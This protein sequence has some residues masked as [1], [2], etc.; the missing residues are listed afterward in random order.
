MG[1]RD[2]L[3]IVAR[4]EAITITWIRSYLRFGPD[5]PLW[6]FVA[7][8]LQALN[9]LGTHEKVV[10]KNLR[11]NVFL[12]SWN[13][14][15]TDLPHDLNELMKVAMKRD[16]KM[17]GLAFERETIRK[18][19]IWYHFRST[20]SRGIFN[21]GQATICLK[22]KHRIQ[23]VGDTEVLARRL[24]AAGHHNR[25][26]CACAACTITR[27]ECGDCSSPHECFVKARTLLDS[28][29]GKWNPLNQQP[30]D[31]EADDQQRLTANLGQGEIRFNPHATNKGGLTGSFRIFCEKL[32]GSGNPPDL[33]IDPEPDEEEITVYTD[34]SAINNGKEN[35]QAGAGI[36]Y[37]PEDGRNRAIRVPTELGP[38]NNVGELL[39]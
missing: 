39:A 10:D 14:K 22:T 32:R 24:D 5:R 37:G 11:L 26:N 12:Q 27:T 36:Y 8:E 23:T 9:I 6:A 28:L 19:N 2:L 33:R 1:G 21:R 25:R 16:V 7:D 35:A 17:E 18:I 4:N 13:S 29:Q 3:D 20:A 30:E 34:G 31:Y 38:S 15:R